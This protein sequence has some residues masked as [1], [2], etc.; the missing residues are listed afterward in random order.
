ML[1]PVFT[2]DLRSHTRR[3]R[4]LWLR[5]LFLV[6][7]LAL[8]LLTYSALPSYL[9]RAQSTVLADYASRFVT[10]YMIGQFFFLLIIGPTYVASAISEERQRGTLD[11]LFTSDLTSREIIMGKYFSRLALLLQY[12]VIGLPILA[13][14]QLIGGVSMELIMGLMLGTVGCLASLTAL[15]LLLSV[16]SK[17]SKNALI[18]TFMLAIALLIVWFIL[19]EVQ[20]SFFYDWVLPSEMVP[21]AHQITDQVLHLNPIYTTAQLRDVLTTSGNIEGFALRWYGVGFLLHAVL[22]TLLL[23]LSIVLIRRRFIKQADRSVK[24]GKEI[25]AAH[26]PEVWESAPL[27][28]KERYFQGSWTAWHWFRRIIFKPTSIHLVFGLAA[29]VFVAFFLFVISLVPGMVSWGQNESR[30][31]ALFGIFTVFGMLVLA[32]FLALIRTTSGIA[33]EKD[34]NTWEALIASPVSIREI[35]LSRLYGGFLSARWLLLLAL[36]GLC[37]FLI[38]TEINRANASSRFIAYGNFRFTGGYGYPEEPMSQTILKTL[39]FLFSNLGYLYFTLGFGVYFALASNSTIR[40]IMSALTIMIMINLLPILFRSFMGAG[41]SM[42]M[43]GVIQALTSPAFMLL[44][45]GIATLVVLA[46]ISYYRFPRLRWIYT[47]VK[48]LGNLMLLNVM[49]FVV[50]SCLFFAF[51][52]IVEF[53]RLLLLAAPLTMDFFILGDLF[54]PERYYRGSEQMMYFQLGSALVFA[55]L[56]LIFYLLAKR[57]LGLTSGRVEHT[58]MAVKQRRI[59]SR[60]LSQPTTSNQSSTQN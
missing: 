31:A 38:M 25:V 52:G 37:I 1:G 26:N 59:A 44:L 36:V 21:L 45:S 6:M 57:K 4:L 33:I 9:A 11:Y 8:F 41:N 20:N 48:W 34:R 23:L 12:V 3:P 55:V 2:A 15:T 51:G 49:I 56:G 10:L 19:Y 46:L 43:M 29:F 58:R 32:H 54:N 22:A 28:W 50:I 7:L 40:N 5:L 42:G 30:Y 39:G 47:F 17:N 16:M 14:V 18:R 35:I 24:R 53:S 60:T 13:L 27:F